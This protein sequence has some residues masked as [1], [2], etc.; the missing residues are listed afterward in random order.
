[1]IKEEW[2]MHS[3]IFGGLMFALFPVVLLISIF[4]FSLFLPLFETILPIK[5]IAMLVHYLFLLLGMSVGGFG[6]L[7]REVM[8]RRFGQASLLA[9]SSRTLPVSERKI[10][11]NFFVK[12][13]IYYF[14]LWVLPFVAGFA[15]A[16]PFISIAVGSPLVLLL[17]LTF[18][19]LMGLSIVFFL[20]T[21]Y[22]HSIKI[23]ALILVLF[24]VGFAATNYRNIAVLESL[25][26]FS[27][28]L[29]PAIDKLIL[30]TILI[31]VLPALSLI[32]FKV[33]FPEKK[34]TF[35]NSLEKISALFR[36]SKL[37]Y[38]IS[39]DFL[40]L[41][42]SEGGL[43]KIIFSF[44]FPIALTWLL[45]FIFLRIVTTVNFLVVFAIFLGAISST[46]YNWLTEFDIFTSY[47]FL[48]VKASTII[49]SKI[50]SYIILNIIS[51]V[52]LLLVSFSYNQYSYFLPALFTF[53][54][55]SSYTLSMTIYLTGLY[56]NIFL[57]NAN[58]LVKY[59][60]SISPILLILIFL[61]IPN[62][63]YLLASPIL[64][65]LA[66][67]ILKKS[68]KKWDSEEQLSF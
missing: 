9:Y 12:D 1:M 58:I 67:Y 8:N 66:V 53:V 60:F 20:S 33:D 22:V 7:G 27:F 59:L 65:F 44:L 39:K 47:S 2:R 13:L 61:A 37:S 38:F 28:F 32:F 45:L 63:F 64:I 17:T 52:I 51:L 35:K 57:Y 14:F 62:P 68:Y 18:S 30:P 40:D 24:A 15:L 42:R 3:S 41:H 43:A 56:P 26:T 54:S 16:T 48:P 25:P 46:I 34:K 4:V 55:V 19:F 5:Q 31:L 49:K 11:L 21:V 29:E 6:L 36:F 50:N 10:F 23:L